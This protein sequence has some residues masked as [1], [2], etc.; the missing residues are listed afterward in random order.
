M[1]PTLGTR[2]TSGIGW[3]L[4]NQAVSRLF[5]IGGLVIFA[6]LLPPADFGL[7]AMAVLV[8]TVVDMLASFDF[9]LGL[10]QKTDAD[11]RHWNAAFTLTLLQRLGAATLTAAVARPAAMG[12]DMPHLESLLYAMAAGSAL[13]GLQNIGVVD[14][15]RRLELRREFWFQVGGRAAGFAAT[16]CF[17]LL[18]ANAWALVAGSLANRGA[19]VVLSYA[20]HRFRPR[21]RL[22]AAADLLNFSK[23][24]FVKNALSYLNHK[25]DDLVVARTTGAAMV[26]QYS[27]SYDIA[28][29]GSTELV[30]PINRVAFPG[31]AR[32]SHDRETLR[33]HFLTVVSHVAILTLPLGAGTVVLAEPLVTVLLGE[34]WRPAIPLLRVFGLAGMIHGVVA[35]AGPVYLA[36]GKPQ[37]SAT[38]AAARVL[39]LAGPLVWSTMTFGAIG[40]AW[41]QLC[42]NV[43]FA[44][45]TYATLASL[46]DLRLPETLAAL[47]RPTAAATAMAVVISNFS[48]SVATVMGLGLVIA[49][50]AAAY[51][52]LLIGLWLLV[53]RPASAEREILRFVTMRR[54]REEAPPPSRPEID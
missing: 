16:L 9:D 25:L 24:L 36:V 10:I 2:M 27:V 12:L 41:T 29:M 50:G 47:W 22:S 26:G 21:L 17:A 45:I 5:D 31:Y 28:S 48:D 40:A 1:R 34:P 32:A 6:R 15:R 37:I 18:W 30:F 14:F 23:W 4:A 38:F 44:P 11:T 3:M 20:P 53:G 13:L 33:R 52:V 49:G 46:L 8:S 54:E 35:N 39:S 43:V 42:C 7:F 19:S 51:A